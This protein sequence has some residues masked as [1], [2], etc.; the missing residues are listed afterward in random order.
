MLVEKL[1]KVALLGSEWVMYLL[2]ALSV[3]SIAA[4]FE[5][6]LFFRKRNDDV[7]E[8]GEKL[9]QKLEEGD[10][11]GARALLKKSPSIEAS[12]I[13]PA[14][15]Y[16]K[17]SAEAVADAI[18]SGLIRARQDMERGSNLLGTLGNNAPFIGLLGTVIGVIIAFQQLGASQSANSMSSVM[19]G[20]A[21][22]LI[23]TGVGLFVALPAVVAYNIIQ[24]KIGDIES[25][26]SA[27]ARDVTAILKAG[28][29]SFGHRL[30][31]SA[32]E[33]ASTS[34]Q[35]LAPGHN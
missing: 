7:D 2:L 4:M 15:R 22:A 11:E 3:F 21:E 9:L 1:L 27:L 17:A 20:I 33:L 6:W 30:S 24:K 8:L 19:G 32:D 34:L 31:A 29:G 13:E 18:E 28:G 16:Y 5:R 35:E 10:L 26:V 12:V 23:A 14:L 25:N